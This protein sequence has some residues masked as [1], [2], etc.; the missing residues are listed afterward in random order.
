VQIDLGTFPEDSSSNAYYVNS[1]GQVVGTSEDRPHML[2][3]VGEHAFLWEDGGPMV[4]L[5]TLIP[6]GSGLNLTYAVAINNDGVIAGFGVPPGVPPEDYEI[7]GHAYILIPCED[8]H[9][10]LEGC[11]N[12]IVD[13]S[14]TNAIRPHAHV[15]LPRGTNH[16]SLQRNNRFHFPALVP[17]N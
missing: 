17:K 12:S 1:R 13:A 8:D 14:V 16:G 15:E 4:D 7:Q 11:D 3:G 5:N 2:I 9:P 6:A 10:N